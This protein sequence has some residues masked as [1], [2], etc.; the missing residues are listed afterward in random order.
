MQRKKTPFILVATLVVM[1]GVVAVI[2][3][4]NAPQNPHAHPHQHTPT[5]RDDENV[6]GTA[7]PAPDKAAVA[8]GVTRRNQT[9]G[10]PPEEAEIMRSGPSPVVRVSGEAVR[11]TINDATTTTHWYTG[12]T[13]LGT[14]EDD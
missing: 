5:V 12:K 13:H 11:P 1:L 4:R 9:P 7:R 8:Q 6:I 3:A 2:N 10:M 14:G